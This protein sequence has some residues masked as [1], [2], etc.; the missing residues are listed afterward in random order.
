M[1][2]VLGPLSASSPDTP[3]R[4]SVAGRVS[5]GFPSPALEHAEPPLSIDEMVGLREPSR[6]LVRAE[7]DSLKNIGIFDKDVM[8]V[9]KALEPLDGDVVVVCIG[10]DF[11]AK[12]Y[13]ER[14]GQAPLLVAHNPAFPN[15]EVGDWEEI[16]LWGVVL[17]SLHRLSR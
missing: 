3:T 15:I 14:P 11:V 5:C 13:R 2:T 16:E 8:V 9:C 17:Y 12:Q 4:K 7:G 6:W 1:L 10:P